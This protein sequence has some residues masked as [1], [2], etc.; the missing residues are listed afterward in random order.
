MYL[1][2][3]YSTRCGINTYLAQTSDF[4]FIPRNILHNYQSGLN[5]GKVLVISPAELEKYYKEVADIPHT[6]N[7]IQWDAEVAIPRGHRQEFLDN[8]RH[9]IQ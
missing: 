4:V 6:R 5:G 8:L 9:L 3:E 2:G 1:D 7:E